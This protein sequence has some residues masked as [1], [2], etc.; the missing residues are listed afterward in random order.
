[1]PARR[2]HVFE[3]AVLLCGPWRSHFSRF[4]VR[5]K[6]GR[7]GSGRKGA[8][9]L[10]EVIV[11]LGA[12]V[13]ETSEIVGRENLK[14]E[15][16]HRTTPEAKKHRN[17]GLWNLVKAIRGINSDVTLSPCLGLEVLSAPK[18]PQTRTTRNTAFSQ[19]KAVRNTGIPILKG[20]RNAIRGPKV[21]FC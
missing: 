4:R 20:H 16:T 1:M 6:Q 11:E 7:G 3:L 12:G 10:F 9:A 2:T 8:K 14:D 18:S 13:C 15:K 5:R 21:D 17:R 19:P